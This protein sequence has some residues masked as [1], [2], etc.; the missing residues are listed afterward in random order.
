MFLIGS[1]RGSKLALFYTVKA[2]DVYTDA[3][4]DT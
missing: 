2:F 1:F 3:L 4:N